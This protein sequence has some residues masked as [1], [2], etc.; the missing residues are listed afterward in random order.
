MKR[1]S[2]LPLVAMLLCTL[3]AG[4]LLLGP[5]AAAQDTPAPAEEGPLDADE[6]QMVEEGALQKKVDAAFGVVVGKMDA[7]L[8]FELSGIPWL[9]GRLPVIENIPLIVFVLFLGGIFFTFRYG[10]V[11]IRLFRH[12][13]DVVRGRYDEPHHDGEISHFWALTS[14]LSATVGLGNIAGVAIAVSEGGPGTVFWMWVTAFLG[15]SLKFSSCTLAQIY[16]RIKKDGAV[17]GGPMVYLDE[18]IRTVYPSLGWLGRAFAVIYAVFIFFA[19][20]G[21]GNLFQSNQTFSVITFQF[22]GE[23]AVAPAWAPWLVGI[24]LAVF[25]GVVIIGGIRRIGVVTS[26]L[27]PAMCALYC[28]VCVVLVLINWTHIP[29]T[30]ASI[31]SEAFAPKPAL[32]GG[33]AT[34][35]VWGLRRAAFSNEAGLGSA[36]IAHSAAKTDK[37]VREGVVAMLGPFIDTI[38]VCTMTALAILITDA[39]LAKDLQ[40]VEI[41]ALAFSQLGFLAPYALA[42]AVF[43][44]AYSTI[45]SWSYYGERAIEYLLGEWSIVPYR[46]IYVAVVVVGPVVSLSNVVNF[47]DMV[48]LTLAFPNIIG[49]IFLSGQV[50]R[51]V[52]EYVGLLKSGNMNP[53]Q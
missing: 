19:A 30:I 51:R 10:F 11:N 2:A 13:F 48:F 28:V 32:A 31:F 21:A 24:V 41:T 49:M 40:G 16:R 37:P 3:L 7:V 15:M 29:A 42:A 35:F 23:E 14:A 43:I 22:Y 47:S 1:I 8:F 46:A 6:R 9:E 33:F 27:V 34:V 25:A 5:E 44:F 12:A 50:K 18:G 52:D 38:V 4:F 53:V 17:L 20:L 39:H 45:I 36:A 26:R